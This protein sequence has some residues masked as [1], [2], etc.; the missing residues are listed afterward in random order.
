MTTPALR[1]GPEPAGGSL[2]PGWPTHQVHNQSPPLAGY[3]VYRS[4]L[5]LVEAV[6]REGAGWADEGLCALGRLA[7][8][9]EAIGWGAAAD[10]H[11]P[12]L[13]TH[14]RYGHR[15]DEV[16]YHPAYHQLMATAVGHGLHA[17][18]WSEPRPGAHLARAAKFAVWTQVEA[19]HGCPVSMTYSA[20]PALRAQP[21]VARA[22]E[23]G[24][25]S[26]AYDPVLRPPAEK[27][28][29]LCGMAMTEKQGG[30]DV[31]AN[32]TVAE[33]VGN[34]GAGAGPG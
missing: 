25:T 19:G 23:P 15:I 32:T 9:E 16:E 30:S 6:H 3:D 33:P 8:S 28:G 34:S 17:S 29:L 21:E 2:S 13:R 5:A 26:L 27:A 10:A 14:D 1:H 4:D 18:P 7:G 20:V 31:R 24:L 12:V 11:P 22:W